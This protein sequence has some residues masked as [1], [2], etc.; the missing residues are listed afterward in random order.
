MIAMLLV[1]LIGLVYVV[2]NVLDWRDDVRSWLHR[3]SCDQCA[4]AHRSLTAKG[5]VSRWP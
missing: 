1:A 4:R 3:R 5:L 2:V